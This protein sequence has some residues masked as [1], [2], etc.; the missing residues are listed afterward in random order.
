MNAHETRRQNSAQNPYVAPSSVGVASLPELVVGAGRTLSNE[1][2]FAL[3]KRDRHE[4]VRVYYSGDLKVLCGP[5]VSIVGTREVSVEGRR[6]SE[7]LA[8]ELADQGVTVMSGLARGV[9]AAAHLA[10]IAAGGRTAAVI[11]TP[12][13]KCYPTENAKLQEEI[14]RNH[15]LLSPFAPGEITYRS[16]F[17]KRNRVMAML[18]DATVIVE[19]SDTSGTLHQ[20]AECQRQGRWL[21]IMK[22]VAEN[23]AL[24]WPKSFIGK[25]KVVVL[26]STDQ[27]LERTKWPN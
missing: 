2:Q 5:C 13:D 19:A 17:P 9:D 1:R 8:R 27:I 26:S 25:P 23:P 20:A 7:R 15:L 14:Y 12:L 21:F 3:L 4:E 22:S 24:T 18:S 16:S 10:T 11:G 6:R